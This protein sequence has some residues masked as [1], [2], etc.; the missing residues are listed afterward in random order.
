MKPA[1]E[2]NNL[3]KKYRKG[4]NAPYLTLRDTLGGIF[5][6]RTQK[7]E[8][9]EF[10]ALKDINLK[11]MPGEVVGIIGRN[12]AGKST[13]LKVLSRI[14]H[15]TQGEVILRGSVGS[16]LEVGTGFHQEL[17]G[18]ENI[19][20]NGAVLG[21]SRT[22]INQKFDEIVSFAEISEF[23]DTPVKH[24]S[25][26]MY[27]RLAFAVAANLESDILLVD[28]VLAVGD[29]IFQKKCLNKMNEVSKSEG[30]T[31]LLVSHNRE[32]IRSLCKTAILFDNGMVIKSGPTDEVLQVYDEQIRNI[33]INQHTLLSNE[34]Y[35][36][37]NG[38]I[39]FTSVKV[40][41]SKGNQN[42][43]YK[44]GEK[45]KL[46][47]A[48]LTF[49]PIHGLKF[50]LGLRSGTT[51]ELVT[52]TSQIISKS[53]ILS[54][55]Q[56][57]LELELDTTLLLPGE[58]PIYWHLSELDSVTINIDVIDDLTPPIIIKT[59]GVKSQ[60][61]YFQMSSRIIAQELIHVKK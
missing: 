59:P 1:I 12:G 37:G 3:S 42:F 19:Y 16:L 20:L 6:P 54:N 46:A 48:Y 2:I 55:T 53:K 35:R 60:I 38:S 5:S 29:A 15:P 56:G 22:E 8:K 32:A 34:T 13:F 50:F 41:D 47:I 21:M 58:Y 14:T 39:R 17:T 26:G 44:A 27:I 45:I 61:G 40:C 9:D 49:K 43:V 52:S 33:E 7:L 31:V 24:Y 28:E 30:R 4:S 25:S 11:I 23:I 10:W 18:R 57:S 36:R 51:R